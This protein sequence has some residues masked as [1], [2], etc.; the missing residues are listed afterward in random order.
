M[1]GCTGVH[2]LTHARAHT[3]ARTHTHKPAT[4]TAC[5]SRPCVKLNDPATEASELQN[6]GSG[7][8]VGGIFAMVLGL[9]LIAMGAKSALG[10]F[11]SHFLK[12]KNDLFTKTGLGRNIDIGIV[13][14][15]KEAFCACRRLLPQV[16]RLLPPAP[17]RL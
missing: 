10:L 17:G 6:A 3:L 2:T 5:S 9:A 14:K 1:R 4:P 16:R 7:L 12:Y 15:K 8:V 11:W 13:E